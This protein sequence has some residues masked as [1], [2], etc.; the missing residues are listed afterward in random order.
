MFNIITLKSSEQLAQKVDRELQR[1]YQA[2]ESFLLP[3][4]QERFSNGEGKTVVQGVCGQDIYLVA[5]VG[6]WGQTYPFR[7]QEHIMAP[8]EHF[9]DIKR[10]ISAIGG[11]ANKITVIM[12]L[13]YQSR[14]DKR[15]SARESLDC[16]MALQELEKLG[17]EVII[18]YDA[19]NPAVENAVP[20]LPFYNFFPHDEMLKSMRRLHENMEATNTLIISPDT[21]AMGRARYWATCLQSDVGMFYKRRDY[22][23]VENGKNPIVEQIY[24]GR[25]L[26]GMKAVIVDDMIAT[27]GSVLDVAEELKKRGAREVLVAV[28][29][30]FFT[31]GIAEFSKAVKEGKVDEVWTT[32]L[33]YLPEELKEQEWLKVVDLAP[34]L[35]RRIYDLAAW[36]GV[37]KPVEAEMPVLR[38]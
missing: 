6:N 35:A 26:T 37:E 24:L 9:Q 23:V 8:D 19:H 29:F 36:L 30:A 21:G 22:S 14:Q 15:S 33:S 17:V 25:D 34:D 1:L 3:L 38:R 10:V 4:K 13:L 27:G 5:D 11:R 20:N 28:S 32:N 16:A 2:Q 18:T 12:P 7:G 31:E